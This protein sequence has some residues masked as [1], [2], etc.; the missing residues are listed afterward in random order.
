MLQRHAAVQS[1]HVSSYLDVHHLP[2]M[3]P[4]LPLLHSQTHAVS[5]AGHELDA[6]AVHAVALVRGRGE[7]L[8]LRQQVQYRQ[9]GKARRQT[10]DWVLARSAEGR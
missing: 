7:A 9:Q 6:G 1:T 8:T 3:K 2:T 4:L 5:L 10:T